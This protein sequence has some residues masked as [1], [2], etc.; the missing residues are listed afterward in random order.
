[1]ISIH[2]TVTLASVPLATQA[3]DGTFILSLLAHD[4]I[5]IGGK[6]PWRL[7]WCGT[8]ARAFYAQHSEAL[9]PGALLNVTEGTRLW[10]FG[11]A[12]KGR[13]G[14]TELRAMVLHMAMADAPAQPAHALNLFPVSSTT[15]T[16]ISP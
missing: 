2:G 5:G 16:E 11:D 15:P 3:S 9:Q 7:T 1:M 12:S 10:G 13:H 8:D 14:T 6:T 4:H